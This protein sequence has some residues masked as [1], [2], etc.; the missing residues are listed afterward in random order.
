MERDLDAG[1]EL[2]AVLLAQY[3]KEDPQVLAS[4]E[5]QTL[6][7]A[8]QTT[9]NRL[10]V[11]RDQGHARGEV[12]R[13]LAAQAEALRIDGDRLYREAEAAL[14]QGN[15]DAARDRLTRTGERYD[16]S[17]VIE[18]DDNLR[19]IR[20]DRLLRL[21]AEITMLENE[22]II[23]EVRELVNQAKT[24]Y[25]TGNFEQSEEMLVRAQN[26]W[27]VTNVEPNPEVVY[28]LTLV[29]GALSLR[30][31]GSSLP[32]RPSIPR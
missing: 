2:G 20:D 4:P 18:D 11:L 27:R 9:V 8:A 15:F 7:N 25:Y 30:S 23:R 10:E 31:A 17:L 29:R 22:R 1:L 16:S 13:N 19:A 6:Y 12:A 28:W 3:K 14:S 24:T 21:G 32:R 26:R 5:M